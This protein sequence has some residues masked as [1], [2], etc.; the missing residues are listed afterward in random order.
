MF[1][2]FFPTCPA[3]GCAKG[4]FIRAMATEQPERNYL[5]LEIRR[6]TAAV[7]LER[8]AGLDTQNCHVVCCNANVS[9][10]VVTVACCWLTKARDGRELL[11][12]SFGCG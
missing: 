9:D 8:A 11:L 5:G 10:H 1:T 2:L 4:S 12:F 7:A 3:T 6:P